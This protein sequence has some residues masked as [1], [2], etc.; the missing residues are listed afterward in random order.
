MRSSCARA[1]AGSSVAP[2]P[3]RPPIA[4]PAA[5]LVEAR[6]KSRRERSMAPSPCQ[7]DCAVL[8]LELSRAFLHNV[9]MPP[10]SHSPTSVAGYT[11]G[12]DRDGTDVCPLEGEG[13]KCA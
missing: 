8:W 6:R 11:S 5:A 7:Q 13:L 9:Q 10:L 4:V 2:S 1:V 12:S 3:T